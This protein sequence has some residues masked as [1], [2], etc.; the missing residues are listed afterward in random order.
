AEIGT[1]GNDDFSFTVSGDGS[2]FLAALKLLADGGILAGS[3]ADG[4]KGAGTLNAGRGLYVARRMV[5]SIMAQSHA[6]VPHSGTTS[7]TVLASVSVP[8]GL[9][10]PMDSLV[11]T[12]MWS[13]SNNE[14]RKIPRLRFGAA[15][16][17][18]SRV[19]LAT[20]QTTSRFGRYQVQISNRGDV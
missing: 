15:N 11:V 6:C 3:P 2:Q 13:W 17:L 16:D 14:K 9:L 12:T 18:T 5:P 7:E 20:T 10:G 19:L 8:G 1:V 4:S